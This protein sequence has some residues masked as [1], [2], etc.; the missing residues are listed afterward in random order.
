MPRRRHSSRSWDTSPAPRRAVNRCRALLVIDNRPL[1][2]AAW[3]HLMQ[4]RKRLEKATRDVHRHEESDEPAFRAWLAATFP[5]LLSSVRTL[6]EEVAAK[7]RLAGA[8]DHEAYISGRSPGQVWREWQRHGGLPPPDDPAGDDPDDP[9][10]DDPFND[11]TSAFEEEMKRVFSDVGVDN[12]DPFADAF[13]DFARDVLGIKLTPPPPPDNVDARSLYRRLVRH[14]HP[15]CGGDWTPA[16]ARLWQQVQDAWDARD[17]DWLARIEAE[18]EAA[19]DM[20]EPT[21]AVS[22]LR[23]ALAEIDAAR[24]DA[25]RR[26][27]QYRK[28][29]AW[30]FSLRPPSQELHE[31]IGRTLR[32]DETMLREQ[33]AGLNDVFHQWER[34]RRRRRP[35]HHAP[36]RQCEFGFL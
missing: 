11:P 33:L 17:A 23:L 30:R 9:D 4:A 7:S 15:D 16:R 6:A 28:Q 12:D 32:R 26:V 22:R 14:L 5:T 25:E 29:D 8:V 3:A 20:L 10:G 27:R 34:V 35:A 21:S 13:R 2:Q 31:R 36:S 18:W 19:N 24:R 1:H